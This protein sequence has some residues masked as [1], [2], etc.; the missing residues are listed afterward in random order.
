M[1]RRR[2]IQ[3]LAAFSSQI[4]GLKTGKSTAAARSQ[5]M[6][7]AWP[8]GW[9]EFGRLFSQHDVQNVMA[10]NARAK[11]IDLI[12]VAIRLLRKR[13]MVEASARGK[14]RPANQAQGSLQ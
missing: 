7:Q 5:A 9:R 3:L 6:Q 1:K 14:V 4:A 8:C 12:T 11:E 2:R 10:E 13:K